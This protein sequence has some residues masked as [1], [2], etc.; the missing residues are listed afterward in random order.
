[1]RWTPGRVL[2]AA[3]GI[4]LAP[5]TAAAQG[6]PAPKIDALEPATVVAGSGP[7]V[8]T[9]TGSHFRDGAVVRWNGADRPT[10]QLDDTRLRVQIPASDIGQAG[11]AAI[12]V[13]SHQAGGRA[14][15]PATLAIHAAPAL[16]VAEPTAPPAPMISSVS[17]TRVAAGGENLT[18][19]VS[20]ANFK[21]DAEV[22]WNGSARETSGTATLLQA[23]IGAA[24][25]ARPG[26]AAVTVVNPGPGARTS[27]PASVQIEHRTP[28]LSAID[29]REV[30]AGSG[31]F[32]LRVTG[33]EFIRTSTTVL[34]NGS[35]RPTRFIGPTAVVAQIAAADVATAGSA[36][37]IV[38]TEVPGSLR[39][40][41]AVLFTMAQPKPT[42]VGVVALSVVPLISTFR[43]RDGL[44]YV[45]PGRS[46]TLNA[47]VSG[48][49]DV[50][51]VARKV[52]GCAGDLI[53]A[54]WQSYSAANPPAWSSA[55]KGLKILCFQVGRREGTSIVES[56]PVEDAIEVVEPLVVTPMGGAPAA[57]LTWLAG[58][59]PSSLDAVNEPFVFAVSIASRTGA[60]VDALGERLTVPGP[61]G[62]HGSLTRATLSGGQG[63]TLRLSDCPSGEVITAVRGRYG[64]WMDSFE[65]GCRPWRQDR[66]AHGN[67][68]WLGKVGGSGGTNSFDLRCPTPLA[69]MGVQVSA[70]TFVHAVRLLCV[71]PENL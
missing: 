4:L 29:P 45:T 30:T 34:W 64:S 24:D 54:S 41:G 37:I 38:R 51:R 43:I 63:G 19:R 69:A 47:T 23:A 62:E 53:P 56:A 33:A 44:P 21:Q 13:F 12:T 15:E 16:P 8:L 65:A 71:V 48:S 61:S 32:E 40:S 36:E 66:G 25:L 27:A 35:P 2:V 10:T 50:Y 55:D 31:G 11:T 52:R 42:V 49:P 46:V 20:G 59:T 39:R 1:M 9:V 57:R 3:C 5:L 60:Y 28:V 68:R 17:P 18:L 22:H 26:T 58:L 14:S 6:P 70:G 7:L 67:V